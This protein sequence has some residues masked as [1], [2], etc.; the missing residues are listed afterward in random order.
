MASLRHHTIW[1]GLALA[2]LWACSDDDNKD[3]TTDPVEEADAGDAGGDEEDAG[4]TEEEHPGDKDTSILPIVF[5]HGF[6]GSASQFDSQ[7]QRFVA[8]DYPP[9]KL[10][11]F[12]HDGAGFAVAD[13]VAGLDKM[14]DEARTRFGVEQV[15]LSGHSR[16]TLV[17]ITYLSDPERAKKVAKLILLDG[18]ACNAAPA[19]LPCIAPNKAGLP[20]QAHVQVATSAES[21]KMQYKFLF[22]KEPEVVD[23]VKQD[24]PVVISGRAVNF[25]ANT[26]REGRT[27]DIFELKA[28]TGERVGKEIASITIPASGDWGPVTVNPD[29]Y[30]ELRLSSETEGSYQH[31]Y[32]QRFLRSTKFIRLLSGPP[33]SASRVNTNAG[34]GH[35]ALT[36]LRMREWYGTNAVGGAAPDELKITVKSTSGDAEVA[37]AITADIKVDR[38]AVYLHDDKATPKMT[39]LAPLPYFPSQ[40]FQT[41]LDIYLPASDPP[42]GTI[43]LTNIQRGE[44]SKPQVLSF[45]N[46][47][48][49]K[50]TIMV[51]FADF[52]Q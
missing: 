10:S 7:A 24:E 25:P 28:E 42:T 17:S 46:W 8:N 49:D 45:P 4:R 38:I 27:L 2:S 22:D 26:G 19:G 23:I 47:S 16:G 12:D 6:A 14:I 15:F 30:Y 11:A 44:T 48:S 41:G 35:A 40:S 21:F 51:M 52:A 18:S 33:E 37:N 1:L 29:K 36:L 31:F 43:T 34:P 3:K 50:H 39:T 20:G 13:Y 5:V 32:F 9:N